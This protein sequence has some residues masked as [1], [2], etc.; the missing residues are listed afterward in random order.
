[1][2]RITASNTPTPPGTWLMMPAI[3]AAAYTARKVTKWMWAA[4]G[5]SHHSTAADSDTSSTDSATWVRPISG[6]RGAQRPAANLERATRQARPQAVGA[7]R[8]QQHRA[9][10]LR[11]LLVQMQQ[12]RKV[13]GRE[14]QR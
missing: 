1:M 13:L 7:H 10:H 5:S 12:A 3:T 2:N 9:D 14:Q 11:P 6:P 8:A 4:G